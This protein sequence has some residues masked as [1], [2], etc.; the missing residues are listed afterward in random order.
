VFVFIMDNQHQYRCG[1]ARLLD[2]SGDFKAVQLGYPDF[3]KYHIRLHLASQSHGVLSVH[4]FPQYLKILLG[5]L[6]PPLVRISIFCIPTCPA[7]W[8]S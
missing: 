1:R 5:L 2:P 4:G 8:T 3:D 7:R 6:G